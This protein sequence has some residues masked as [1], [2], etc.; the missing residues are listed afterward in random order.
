MEESR[1]AIVSR[2]DELNRM[3]GDLQRRVAV[4]ERGDSASTAEY[5]AE[6]PQPAPVEFHPAGE[7]VLERADSLVPLFGWALLGIAGAYLLR[8]TTES[9]AIP[10]TVGVVAGIGYAAWWLFFAARKAAE[11]PST[12]MVHGLT[13]ALILVPLLLETTVRFHAISGLAASSIIVLFV[14][15]GLAIAWR[16]NVTSIAWITTLAG[17]FTV[18]A[19][20]RETHDGVIWVAAVLA[21]AAAVEFS[22]CRDHWLSL[23]WVVAITADLS[24]LM[25]SFL[26]LRA[27]DP[28]T[29]IQPPASGMVLATQIALLTIYL[30]STVDRTLLRGLTITWFEIGQAAVAFV[31]SIGGALQVLGASKAGALGVG[32]FCLIG[33][34]A[35]YL[36]SF[37]SLDHRDDRNR[38]FYTYSTFAVLLVT[39][40]CWMLVPAGALAAVWAVLAVAALVA[41]LHWSRT[42]LRAHSLLYLLLAIAGAKLLQ[43]AAARLLK[44]NGSSL[45][46]P[47]PYILTL[48]GILACYFVISTL[49]KRLQP[50][51]SDSIE[52]VIV[53]ALA[54][55]GTAGAI[56]GWITLYISGAAPLRT[57]L[58]TALAI[59]VAWAGK[60]Y[61]H[62]E[63]SWLA[64]PLMALAGLKVIADDLQEGKSLMLFLSLIFFGGG[65]VLLPRLLRKPRPG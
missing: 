50:A 16:R 64:Y 27:V 48:G 23:R 51:W 29:G 31:I 28:T 9:G 61:G 19:L 11:K 46:L 3:V 38:N 43:V 13:A 5:S 18:T 44:S 52:Q 26:A 41:G 1:D 8:A 30:S 10:R 53:A 34:T 22:A 36:V 49:G 24:V 17:L 7:L 25:L 40:G 37:A 54:C 2:L 6:A 33:G 45:E 35:C 42:T 39:L 15:F 32:I 65:L 4:L 62:K 57:A 56:A 12:S 14:L 21:I 20:F 47:I 58:L 59:V 55:I 63:L 60:R